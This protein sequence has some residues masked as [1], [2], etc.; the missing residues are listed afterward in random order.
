M[1]RKPAPIPTILPPKMWFF[2][3]SVPGTLGCQTLTPLFLFLYPQTTCLLTFLENVVFCGKD[4][5][6]RNI[7]EPENGLGIN[8]K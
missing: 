7:T 1:Y 2:V 8:S 6:Y 3:E 4:T 5:R